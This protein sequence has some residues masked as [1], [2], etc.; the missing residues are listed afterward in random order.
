MGADDYY[1]FFLLGAM[2][3]PE[4][5]GQRRPEKYILDVLGSYREII[6]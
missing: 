5:I 1:P 2:Q 6:Q 3:G 4:M